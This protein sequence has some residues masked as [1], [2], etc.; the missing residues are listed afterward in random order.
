MYMYIYIYVFQN[1]LGLLLPHQ[2]NF[3]AHINEGLDIKL[4]EQQAEQGTLDFH[5][6]AGF[7]ISVMSKL[8]APARDEQV[9]KLKEIKEIVPL[10]Q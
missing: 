3:K 6:Y 9:A 7:V 1:L 2:K 5:S 4:V 10:Y 8:C